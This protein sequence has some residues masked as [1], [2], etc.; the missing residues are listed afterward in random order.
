MVNPADGG[1]STQTPPEPLAGAARRRELWLGLR[2]LPLPGLCRQSRWRVRPLPVQSPEP[3]GLPPPLPGV[4]SVVV[5]ARAVADATTCCSCRCRCCRRCRRDSG[6][7]R[8]CHCRCRAAVARA[9]AGASPE[10]PV[11]PPLL[12]GRCRLRRGGAVVAGA[13]PSRTLAQCYAVPS[14]PSWDQP[15][16]ATTVVVSGALPQRPAPPVLPPLL[17]GLR[18]SPSPLPPG[19][20]PVLLTR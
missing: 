15:G 17:P 5:A 1:P 3:L 13:S 10:S 11:L 2:A 12:P 20:W 6:A 18:A 16:V 19:P 8:C 4:A 14:V 7:A 9:V